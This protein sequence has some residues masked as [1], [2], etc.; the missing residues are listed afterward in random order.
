MDDKQ[1]KSNAGRGRPK[2][3][4]PTRGLKINIV[5]PESGRLSTR[6]ELL[7]SNTI[8]LYGGDIVKTCKFLKLPQEMVSEI[9]LKYNQQINQA[10]SKS[11][12]DAKANKAIN[13][14]LDIMEKH[15]K[16]IKKK[17]KSGPMYAIDMG[18]MPKH[19]GSIGQGKAGIVGFLLQ[20]LIWHQ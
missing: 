14:S 3:K 15:I 12:N 9:Y 16:E 7:V 5:I 10:L 13:E 2:E 4:S 20:M 18:R 8:I 1:K 11:I 17:Q 6:Q 19:C